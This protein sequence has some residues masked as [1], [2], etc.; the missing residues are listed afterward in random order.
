[1]H[2]QAPATNVVGDLDQAGKDILEEAGPE[3]VALMVDV[4]A[5]PGQKGDRLRVA[6]G[7]FA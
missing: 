2:E 5:K 4:D 6:T 3:P 7:S 1:V